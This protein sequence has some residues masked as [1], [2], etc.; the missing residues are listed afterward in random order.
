MQSLASM[1]QPQRMA[2]INADIVAGRDELAGAVLS[3][4]LLSSGLTEAERD[5]VP[6]ILA[7]NLQSTRRDMPRRARA[8]AGK[9][10]GRPEFQRE[11]DWRKLDRQ[12]CQESW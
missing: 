10:R 2:A 4:P 8:N 7:G 11:A 1:T 5:L 6:S 3:A 12:L 9:S